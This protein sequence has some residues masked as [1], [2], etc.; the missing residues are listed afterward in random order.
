MNKVTDRNFT[1]NYYEKNETTWV[2]ESK[3]DDLEH[4]ICLTIEMNM[5]T[6]VITD[7]NIHFDRYPVKH[8][9]MIEEKAKKLVGMKVNRSFVRKAMAHFM[10]PKGC[11]NILT[12]LNIA[13]PGIIYYYYPHMVRTGRMPRE[14]WEKMI[15]TDLKNA[16]IGH[17]MRSKAS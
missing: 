1:V 4:E 14:A 2:V 7:A 3:L 15:D 5:E 12:L 10:G 9:P 16:C 13:L 6:M 8:C 11:P 17:T